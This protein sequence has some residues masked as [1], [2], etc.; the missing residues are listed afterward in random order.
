[1]ENEKKSYR[2]QLLILIPIFNKYGIGYRN[3]QGKDLFMVNKIYAQSITFYEGTIYY[4]GR[5][6]FNPWLHYTDFIT[7]TW[8]FYKLGTTS[9]SIELVTDPYNFDFDNIDIPTLEV[10]V[11]KI[12]EKWKGT[13]LPLCKEILKT[14]IDKIWTLKK[15][16]T[17][18]EFDTRLKSERLLLPESRSGLNKLIQN[19]MLDGEDVYKI[20][21]MLNDESFLPSDVKDIFLF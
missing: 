5:F 20:Y 16:M 21:E 19:E 1:M 8:D 2:D 10:K 14:R 17:P 18:Q 15:T 7:G 13:D 6:S 4:C 12:A 9:P 11:Q 3:V